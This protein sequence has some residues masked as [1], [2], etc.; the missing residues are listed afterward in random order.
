MY[1]KTQTHVQRNT[2]I[3]IFTLKKLFCTCPQRMLYTILMMTVVQ[4][5]TYLWRG[6]YFRET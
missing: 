4:E 6:I 3:N 5:I 1:I 2:Q